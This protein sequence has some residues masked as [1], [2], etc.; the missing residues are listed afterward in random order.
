[1]TPKQA[2]WASDHDWYIASK[3]AAWITVTVR[4]WDL[5]SG[6]CFHRNFTSFKELKDWAGY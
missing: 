4:D 2:R 1:M 3:G 5:T 6:D